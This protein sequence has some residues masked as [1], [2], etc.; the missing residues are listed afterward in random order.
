MTECEQYEKDRELNSFCRD[1]WRLWKRAGRE[2]YQNLPPWDKL[3]PA[4]DEGKGRTKLHFY[5]F[6]GMIRD[7]VLCDRCR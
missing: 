6:F 3:P 2:V 7:E 1:L 4:S 5:R